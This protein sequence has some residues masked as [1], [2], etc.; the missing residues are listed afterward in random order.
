VGNYCGAVRA[1]GD[2]SL[3]RRPLDPGGPDRSYGVEVARLAGL[4]ESVVER[5]REI[6]RELETAA[7]PPSSQP[8]AEPVVQL[9]LFG[10][11]VHPAVERLR[12]IDANRVTPLQALNLLAELSEAARSG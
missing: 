2:D 3:Y 8:R 1:V 7:A 4:P 10:P 9:G 5:A 12:A 11:P 6:L